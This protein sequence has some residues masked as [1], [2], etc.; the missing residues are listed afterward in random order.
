VQAFDFHLATA[1]ALRPATGMPA[2]TSRRA[3]PRNLAG[4][5]ADHFHPAGSCLHPPDSARGTRPSVRAVPGGEGGG[6]EGRRAH[7][8]PAPTQPWDSP[9]PAAALRYMRIMYCRRRMGR[10]QGGR[11]S[12]ASQQCAVSFFSI[13][14]HFSFFFLLP[15]PPPPS[16]VE[17]VGDPTPFI[18]RH[19]DPRAQ[20]P[21]TH[22]SRLLSLMCAAGRLV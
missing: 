6:L 18:F 4:H 15:P 14:L 10:R 20:S 9:G 12:P 16:G 3:G 8:L 1:G 5:P 13:F 17:R 21:P 19:A 2:S 11:A 7:R 22:R